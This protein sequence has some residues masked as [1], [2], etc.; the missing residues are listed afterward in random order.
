MSTS[1]LVT[2]TMVET[3]TRANYDAMTYSGAWDELDSDLQESGGERGAMRDALEEV[4]PL[5]AAK[6]LQ[7]AAREL[8]LGVGISAL[9]ITGEHAEEIARLALLAR[10]CRIKRGES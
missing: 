1:D 7:D 10:A 2:D 3:A 5:I 8:R 4:A 9:R 6:A